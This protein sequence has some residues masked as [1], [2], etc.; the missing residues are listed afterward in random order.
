MRVGPHQRDRLDALD[1][2]GAGLLEV[3]RLW[4][5]QLRIL[6]IVSSRP[7]L[8]LVFSGEGTTEPAG[9][10]ANVYRCLPASKWPE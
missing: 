4:Q 8:Q 5:T 7:A 3:Q 10:A 2:F 9:R 6:Q 1:V